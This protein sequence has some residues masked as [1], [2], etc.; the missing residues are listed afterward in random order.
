MT[1]R[2]EP[3]SWQKIKWKR[4]S[5]DDPAQILYKYTY[6]NGHFKI[7]DLSKKQSLALVNFQLDI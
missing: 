6:Q 5:P 1:N 7:L 4:Y 3:V 2:G